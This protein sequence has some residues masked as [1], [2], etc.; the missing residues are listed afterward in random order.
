MSITI[1]Y[2]GRQNTSKD[3]DVEELL[4]YKV[5]GNCYL[6]DILLEYVPSLSFTLL[7]IY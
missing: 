3:R 2:N 4:V 5:L 6:F 1:R 7:F